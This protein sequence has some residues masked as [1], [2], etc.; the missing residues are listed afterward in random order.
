MHP[1]VDTDAAISAKLR[2]QHQK[3][4]FAATDLE[5]RLAVQVML[6]YQPRCECAVKG[7]ECAGE[8]LRL[9][10]TR[11]ILHDFRAKRRVADKPAGIAKTEFH[12]ASARSLGFFRR[13]PQNT[14]VRRRVRDMMEYGHRAMPA[15]GTRANG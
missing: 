5:H 4:A 12:F 3:L 9:L 14:A 6:L 7:I 1:G 15:G 11:G 13:V 10:I 8:A 2:K